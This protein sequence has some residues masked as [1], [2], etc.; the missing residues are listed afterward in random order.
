MAHPILL[1]AAK[2]RQLYQI[3]VN[4]SD[5]DLDRFIQ[6]AQVGEF[7]FYIGEDLYYNLCQNYQDGDKYESLLTGSVYLNEAGFSRYFDGAD[8][9]IGWIALK[10]FILEERFRS[11]KS[12][13]VQQKKRNSE[14]IDEIDLTSSFAHIRGQIINYHNQ[15]SIY[16]NSNTLLFPESQALKQ[17]TVL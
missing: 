8:L 10:I 5:T 2:L 9:L 14:L 12:G 15:L 1:T 16:L 4:V 11:T 13:R 6:I 17:I 7:R 3:S